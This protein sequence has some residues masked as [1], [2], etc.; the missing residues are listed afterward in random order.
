VEEQV[1]LGG[2]ARRRD[3]ELMHQG[4]KLAWWNST[5]VRSSEVLGQGSSWWRSRRE[6][7]GRFRAVPCAKSPALFR[8]MRVR[9]RGEGRGE[10][11][12]RL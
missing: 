8:R 7:I 1:A 12:A 2:E 9:I 6:T 4:A 5:M 11:S 3:E 10:P